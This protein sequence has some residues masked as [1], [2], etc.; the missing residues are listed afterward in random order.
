[1]EITFRMHGRNKINKGGSKLLTL[2][3]DILGQTMQKLVFMVIVLSQNWPG[4]YLT[5]IMMMTS[6]GKFSPSLVKQSEESLHLSYT[7]YSVHAYL[8]TLYHDP[9]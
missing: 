6:K 8:K 5:R 9:Y 7:A 4:T 2:G 3:K 1:M